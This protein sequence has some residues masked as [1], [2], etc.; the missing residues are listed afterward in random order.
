MLLII[1]IIIFIKKLI[2]LD[3]MVII[4]ISLNERIL[5]DIDKLERDLGFSGRSEV[6]RAGVRLLISE[7]KEKAKLWKST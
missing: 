6:I 2:I 4:S 3:G 5:K 7:E 1:F